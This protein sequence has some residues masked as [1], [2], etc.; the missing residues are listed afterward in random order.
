MKR[1]T[2]EQ[3]LSSRKIKAK[4][5]SYEIPEKE[6]VSM[7]VGQSNVTSMPGISRL[8]ITDDYLVAETRKGRVTYLEFD[9]VRAI[10]FESKEIADRQAGF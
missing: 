6:V 7:L 1:E 8:S 9:L 4:S 3:I 10:S 2:I 5:G